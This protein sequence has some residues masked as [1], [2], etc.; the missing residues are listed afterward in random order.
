M[1]ILSLLPAATDML[2]AMGLSHLLVGCTHECDL[3]KECG[4]IPRVTVSKIP[5]GSSSGEID[6]LVRESCVTKEPLTSIDR[7]L[8][9][10]LRPDV[11]ISQALCEVC[12]LTPNQLQELAIDLDRS[13][14]ETT[15]IR[16]IELAPKILED[17]FRSIHVLGESI[18]QTDVALSLIQ[19]LRNRM[20]QLE[21]RHRHMPS[22]PTVTLEWLQP[23]F[24]VGHWTPELLK[25]INLVDRLGVPGGH[26]HPCSWDEIVAAQPEVVLFA[27]CGRTRE[28]THREIESLSGTIPW[29]DLTA[30]AKGRFLV[31]DGNSSFSRPGPRLI[32]TL[33]EISWWLTNS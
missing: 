9:C 13:R 20:A 19:D 33:E 17:V 32:A 10:S 6:R 16:W 12:A 11:V 28:E 5:S 14:A 27:C 24:N 21:E 1:R 22:I 4:T 8:V 15:P 31:L 25:T 7:E 3:A 26:S 23:F 29:L 18:G 30:M 2:T